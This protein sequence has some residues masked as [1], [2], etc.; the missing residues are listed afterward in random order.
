MRDQTNSR[1]FGSWNAI[2]LTGSRKR[3]W[4]IIGLAPKRHNGGNLA[5]YARCDC[6]RQKIVTSNN[7]GR[8]S[9]TRCSICEPRKTYNQLPDGES[10][11]NTLYY[12]YVIRAEKRGLEWNLSR[13]QFRGITVRECLYCGKPPS[14][15]RN[16]TRGTPGYQYTGVDRLDPLLGY[17]VEN[18]VPCCGACNRAKSDLTLGQWRAHVQRLAGRLGSW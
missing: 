15:V 16:N 12:G 14:Q 9:G 4:T 17:T 5:W 3:T 1:T 8:G 10:S 13:E 7:W 2:D 11:F 18:V 6:G